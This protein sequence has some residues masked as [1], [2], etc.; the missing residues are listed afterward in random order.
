MQRARICIWGPTAKIL[1]EIPCSVGNAQWKLKWAHKQ[2]LL[3]C[4]AM[5]PGPAE[6]GGTA[7]ISQKEKNPVSQL[8]EQCG[9]EELRSGKSFL[10]NHNLPVIFMGLP[11]SSLNYFNWSQYCKNVSETT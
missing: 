6:T 11:N 9:P 1:P 4:N 10:S 5:E 7:L 3:K 8:E 2:I